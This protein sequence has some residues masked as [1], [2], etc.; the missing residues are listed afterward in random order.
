MSRHVPTTRP[1]R[2]AAAFSVQGAALVAVVVA[3]GSPGWQAARALMVAVLTGLGIGAVLR[4][5]SSLRE[6]LA[7]VF[8]LVGLV[9]GIGIGVGHLARGDADPTAIAATVALLAGAWLILT[10]AWFLV[11]RARRWRKLLALPVVVVVLQF[12][13]L[14]VTVAVVATNVART[15]LTVGPPGDLPFRDVT[16]RADDGILL[17]GWYLP[18][19]NR[20]AVVVLHGSGETRAGV[21]AESTV[22]ANHGYGVLLFDARG[23][24][25]SAGTG[26]SLGWFGDLDVSAAVSFVARRDDVDVARIGVLGESMGGEEAIGAAAND[27]RISAVVAEGATQRVGADRPD[28]GAVERIV[29]WIQD[30][31]ADV[32]TSAHPPQSLFDALRATRPTPVLLIAGASEIATGRY[33][34]SA[35]PERIDLWEMPSTGHTQGLATRPSAWKRRVIAFFDR[36]LDPAPTP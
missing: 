25:R 9:A 32:L 26:M 23:H 16:F 15:E 18:S 3:H 21:R 10:A 22:L 19:R 28:P 5:G 29:A 36:A 31:V 1:G 30:H 8:G 17:S 20:A 13:V 6:T 14:P 11:G 27:P 35:A 34:R 24:G 33:L 12:V 7:I 4:S 2:V